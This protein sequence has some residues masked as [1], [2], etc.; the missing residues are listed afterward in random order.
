MGFD[1]LA[2]QEQ[3]RRSLRPATGGLAFLKQV[4]QKSF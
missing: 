4:L 1:I 2:L 3:L